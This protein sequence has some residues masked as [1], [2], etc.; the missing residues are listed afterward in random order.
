MNIKWHSIDISSS[1][2]FAELFHSFS[3]LFLDVTYF[4]LI[5]TSESFLLE[6]QFIPLDNEVFKTG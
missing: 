6:N 2:V 5:V 4:I 3:K 1:Y